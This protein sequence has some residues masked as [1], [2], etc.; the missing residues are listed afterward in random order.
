MTIN[1]RIHINIDKD[2]D[3]DVNIFTNMNINMNMNIIMNEK[4]VSGMS[5]ED[6]MT[7]ATFDEKG[8]QL[9]GN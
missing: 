3:V 6:G 9:A 2:R 5:F 7:T 8:K 4:Q 1:I